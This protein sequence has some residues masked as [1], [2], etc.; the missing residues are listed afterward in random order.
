MPENYTYT[1]HTYNGT[2]IHI[3][4][5]PATNIRLNNYAKD[6]VANSVIDSVSYGVNGS[7]FVMS[8]IENSNEKKNDVLN[9][10]TYN[11]TPVGSRDVDAMYNHIGDGAIAWNGSHILSFTNVRYSDDISFSTES[12]TWCQGGI[13]LWLGDSNWQTKF[14]NQRAAGDYLNS[15]KERTAMIANMN[16]DRIFLIVTEDKVTTPEFRATIQSY[17]G[18]TDASNPSNTYKGIM[19]DGGGSAQMRIENASGKVVEVGN[20]ESGIYR[21]IPQHINLKAAF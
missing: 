21:G 14:K 12:D 7:F 11:G 9:I 18:I 4:S 10:C 16:T 2:K 3:I 5:T 19:L 17:L 8:P 20:K 1:T 15:N 13:A 6:G